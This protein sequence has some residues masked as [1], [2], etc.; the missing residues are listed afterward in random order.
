M[1]NRIIYFLVLLLTVGMYSCYEEEEYADNLSLGATIDVTADNAFILG[2]TSEVNISVAINTNAEAPV[3][4]LIVTKQLLTAAGESEIISSTV[5][6]DAEGQIALNLSVSDLFSDVPING[7]VLTPEELEPG[8]KWEF[9]YTIVMQ[10]GREL[11]PGRGDNVTQV[12]FTCLS[13]IAGTYNTVTDGGTGDGSGGTASSFTDL[14]YQVTITELSAGT[15]E[16]SDITGGLYAQ[17]YSSSDNPAEFIDICNNIT[18]DAQPD[19]VFGG[20]EFNGTGTVNG[21]GTITITW[22]NNYGDN[23]VTT[24]TQ[25]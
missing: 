13:D 15:Y 19:V 3:A 10:D 23:G 20:D 7:N 5:S 17:I 9:R 14:T 21:D 6:P 4:S 16:I 1:K 22:S 25:V 8:D 12:N 18:I 24:L 2:E 11:T